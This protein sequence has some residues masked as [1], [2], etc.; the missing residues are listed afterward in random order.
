VSRRNGISGV[1]DEEAQVHAP[2]HDRER[3]VELHPALAH[4][5]AEL[6][7]REG[8]RQGHEIHDRAL[9]VERVAV[10]LE[11]QITA[12]TRRDEAAAVYL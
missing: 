8:R 4:S 2:G 10:H 12:R 6:R 7:E 3:G 9:V 5:R 1:A 11:R